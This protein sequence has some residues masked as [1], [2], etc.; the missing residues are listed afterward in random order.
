[1]PEKSRR[2]FYEGIYV[3]E[4]EGALW[5]YKAIEENRRSIA[6]IPA[7]CRARIVV[8]VDPSGASGREDSR[9]DEVGIVVACKGQDGH[10]YIL[11]DLS[12]RAGPAEWARA[13]VNAFHQFRG[14]AI[15][16]ESNFGGEMVR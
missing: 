9:S 2:R 11:A 7:E 5:S 15:V 3:D 14:D 10:A 13:A 6:D 8:G 4:V 1:L 16:A 12:L